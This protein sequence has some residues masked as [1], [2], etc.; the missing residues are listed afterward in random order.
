MSPKIL[1]YM[2]GS[3]LSD[4]L[5]CEV[6]HVGQPGDDGTDLNCFDRGQPLLIQIKRRGNPNK[7][8]GIDVV[9]LIFA[10]AFASGANSG[11]VSLS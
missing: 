1:K 6:R 4:F 3:V 7:T 11:M 9:K 10:S 2:V 5:D 8:E